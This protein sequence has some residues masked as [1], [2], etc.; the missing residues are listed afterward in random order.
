MWA[1]GAYQNIHETKFYTLSESY[2][3]LGAWYYEYLHLSLKL[4]LLPYYLPVGTIL[5]HSREHF[6]KLT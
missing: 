6:V 3:K 2:F 5:N 1:A 4:C